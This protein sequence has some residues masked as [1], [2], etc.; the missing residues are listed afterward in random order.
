MNEHVKVYSDSA[1][2]INRIVQFLEGNRIH[3]LTKDNVESA[4]LAAFGASYFDVDLYVS[5]SD[6]KNAQNIINSY[7]DEQ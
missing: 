3:A 1:I 5:K 4:R 6:L 7:L 2:I